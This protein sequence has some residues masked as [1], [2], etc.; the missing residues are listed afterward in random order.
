MPFPNNLVRL[1]GA[2]VLLFAVGFGLTGCVATPTGRGIAAT[3]RQIESV[4]GIE[5][6]TL[7][8]TTL[9]DGLT[10]SQ[11]INITV[12]VSDGY[13]V[14]D[15]DAAIVWL[16]RE[17]WSAG[18]GRPGSMGISLEDSSGKPL[19]WGWKAALAKR[20]WDVAIVD[21]NMNSANVLVFAGSRMT[22]LTG[23]SW[24]GRV[25]KAPADLFVNN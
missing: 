18:P 9:N 5:R 7:R 10:S 25:P 23:K 3:D 11:T 20:G 13:Q 1:T 22:S 24:P 4:P 17:A 2:C 15:A 21:G 12:A 14:G 19:D 6:A 16:A 8:A